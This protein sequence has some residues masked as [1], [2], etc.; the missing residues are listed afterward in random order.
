VH[1]GERAAVVLHR[2]GL[3]HVD[4][5]PDVVTA[6]VVV[7]VEDADDVPPHDRTG[8]PLEEREARSSGASPSA[9]RWSASRSHE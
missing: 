4:A 7:V 5:V 1:D 8:E 9:T 2:T 6:G 3:V